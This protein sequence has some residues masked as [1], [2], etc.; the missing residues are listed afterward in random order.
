MGFEVGVGLVLG[1]VWGWVGLEGLAWGPGLGL[2]LGSGFGDWVG[3]GLGRDG[4][5]WAGVGLRCGVGALGG[6]IGWGTLRS[7]PYFLR[8]QKPGA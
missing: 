3:V 7:L 5:G 1:G 6:W 8:R 4:W 2:C